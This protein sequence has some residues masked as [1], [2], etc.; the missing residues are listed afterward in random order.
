LVV[1]TALLLAACGGSS[2][3]TSPAP[4]SPGAYSGPTPTQSARPEPSLNTTKV[5][6]AAD[7]QIGVYRGAEVLG[8]KDIQFSRLFGQ[9]RP[10]V[11]NFFAGLCPPCRAEMPAIQS[12]S[13]Q[14]QDSITI[15]GLDVGPFVALGSREDGEALVQELGVTYPTGATFDANVV[16]AYQV[17]GMPTTVFLTPEG[18]VFRTWTGLLTR[19]KLVELVEGLL[20]ASGM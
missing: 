1:V 3:A 17:L 18:K 6:L 5:N 2:A 19:S 11:L 12:V 10:V 13:V 16:R 9:G 7:F 15:F 8:G 4:T 14:Y 20:K